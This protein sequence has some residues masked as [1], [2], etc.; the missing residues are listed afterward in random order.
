MD[1]IDVREQGINLAELANRASLES[2]FASRMA[3]LS[4]EHKR[5][6]VRLLGNPPDQANVPEE[7]WRRVEEEDRK[8]LLALLLPIY[9]A[10]AEQHGL[11]TALAQQQ[12]QLWASAR[13]GRVAAGLV[14][15]TKNRL[16]TAGR[17]WLQRLHNDETV[18]RTEIE[19]LGVSLLGPKRVEI[20]TNTEVPIA[21][22]EGGSAAVQNLGVSVTGYWAHSGLRPRG[23]C[24]A[25]IDPCTTCSPL[26]GLPQ[27]DWYGLLP[28]YAH[29]NCVLPGNLVRIPGRIKAATKS[30]YDGPCVE[31]GLADGSVFSVTENHPVLTSSG[32][33]A[34]G[35]LHKGGDVICCRTDKSIPAGINPYHDD[36]P[37]LIEYVFESLRKSASV[38]ASSVPTSAEDFHGDARFIDSNIEIVR[39]DGFLRSYGDAAH[40]EHL[41]KDAFGL[42]LMRDSFLS[43][44]C[45]QFQFSHS[46]TPTSCSSVRIPNLIPSLPRRQLRPLQRFGHRP[47]SRSYARFDKRSAHNAAS[48]AVSAGNA[49]FRL[50]SHISLHRPIWNGAP[51][52]KTHAALGN[53]KR[54]ELFPKA[55][56]TNA[57]L[58]SQFVNR[59]ASLI[60]ANK[61]VKVRTFM[62]RGHV[63]DLQVGQYALYTCNGAVVHNC[64][65]FIEW[66]TDDG[67]LV[68]YGGRPSA[69]RIAWAKRFDI[70]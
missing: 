32:W 36:R 16:G 64:D 48:D 34:A 13:A 66:I 21:Q 54:A 41:D 40:I 1:S 26:E 38:T 61:I 15:H 45:T 53:A 14:Q 69:S 46:C 31:V 37:T 68:G 59:F 60:T 28:G 56:L 30:F 25:P 57:G 70:L 4:A 47:V 18:T 3:R 9:I 49:N 8:T 2:D 50:A 52:L 22:N 12:G 63:Y 44:L 24:N 65:C 27:G 35:L 17:D 42:G 29:T 62:F 39:A 55:R 5:E 58:A 23:H 67:E 6:L 43:P 20:I 10:A 19:E 11:L 51:S 7:F 33:V